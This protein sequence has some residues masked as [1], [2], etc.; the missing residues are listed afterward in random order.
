MSKKKTRVDNLASR[1]NLVMKSGKLFMGT[2]ASRKAIRAGHAKI[3]VFARNCPPLQRAELEYLAMVSRTAVHHYSG[4]NIDLGTACGKL[5]PCSVLVVMDPG[6][7]DIIESP[8][9]DASE[10]EPAPAPL[11]HLKISKL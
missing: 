1:L 11:P 3:V 4:T 6:D 7:S 2:K 10:P 8:A 9:P 5:F